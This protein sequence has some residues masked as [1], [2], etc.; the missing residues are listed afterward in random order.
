MGGSRT[1]NFLSSFYHLSASNF[2]ER[3]KA[4]S[5]HGELCWL[6]WI[7]KFFSL[8]IRVKIP[9]NTFKGICVL[10][11]TV[12][13]TYI[14]RYVGRY[15]PTVLPIQCDQI[16]RNFASLAKMLKLFGQ[17]FGWF[18]YY[19]ANFYR[20]IS[21]FSIGQIVIVVNGQNWIILLPSGHTGPIT[22]LLLH[23][24]FFVSRSKPT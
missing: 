1:N 15:I 19:L 16:W 20:N 10:K 2:I 24:S 23:S 21:I 6:T 4:A 11:L 17:F 5:S 9:F 13:H 22:V 3:W 14:R 8:K 12:V 7:E 18:I